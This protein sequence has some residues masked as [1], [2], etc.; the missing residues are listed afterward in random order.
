MLCIKP[1][2]WVCV[3][4]AAYSDKWVGRLYAGEPNEKEKEATTLFSWLPK[5]VVWC[6]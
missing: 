5:V 1:K 3:A 4:C 6:E 2:F